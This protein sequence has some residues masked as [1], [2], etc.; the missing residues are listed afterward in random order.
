MNQ[1]GQIT[2]A[3]MLAIVILAGIFMSGCAQMFTAKTKA[4]YVI[5]PDGSKEVLY[6]SDKEQVG[7][8]ATVEK[9][10]SLH[11]KVDRANTQEAVIAATLQL[12]AQ[13]V[14]LMEMLAAKV[15]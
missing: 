8:D 4:Y 6:E 5:R 11:V 2:L 7:L 15:K 1:R 3:V 10:G 12:Q 14:R 13:M 9:D